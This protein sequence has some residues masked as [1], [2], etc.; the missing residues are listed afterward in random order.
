MQTGFELGPRPPALLSGMPRLV[1]LIAENRDLDPWLAATLQLLL[2]ETSSPGPASPLVLQRLA[3]VLFVQAL[4]SLTIQGRCRHPGLAALS[5]PPVHAALNAMRFF[6]DE[7]CGQC[8]PCRVGTVKAAELMDAASLR[9]AQAL[10]NPLD[11]LTG[12]D[13]RQHT[14]L[15][16]EAQAQQADELA[17]TVAD[18][19]AVV[20]RLNGLTDLGLPA[21]F[22]ADPLARARAWQVRKGLYTAVAGARRPGSTALL[23]DI[24]VPMPALTETVSRLGELTAGHGY[25]D[26][27]IFGH[28]KE[29]N[30]HFMI[31]PDLREPTQ[32]DVLAAIKEAI[33]DTHVAALY[34]THDL[35]V[36]AQVADDIMVLRHGRMVEL[37]E[38]GRVSFTASHRPLAQTLSQ[39]LE[40]W[41][42]ELR[43]PRRSIP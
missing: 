24:V 23:E 43:S 41:W 5:D 34:I 11:V 27:V 9:V 22:S 1:P 30:L 16:V 36:V 25:R 2:A 39:A 13:V 12:L 6:A 17:G 40:S 15:L 37:G 42:N 29:G 21:A 8:T 38:T 7:S 20:A 35:A 3:D 33:R 26:S 14:A 32:I 31:D 28:A 10:P 19:T 18:L 4:R